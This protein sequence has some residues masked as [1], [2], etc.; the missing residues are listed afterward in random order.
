MRIEN[1]SELPK[2]NI[3]AVC[4]QTGI[5]PVTLR[6][7]ERRYGLLAP[8]RSSSNYRRYSERDVAVLRWLKAR[9]DGGAV[10]STAAA[11]LADLR[12]RN[13]WPEAPAALAPQLAVSTGEAPHKYAERLFQALAARDESAAAAVFAEVNT[14]F[15]IATA[16]AEVFTPC[17]VHVGEAWAR[18]DLLIATEHFASGFLRGRLIGVFQAM[19]IARSGPR[20][21]VGCAPTELHDIGGLM[22]AVLL[23]RRGQRVEYLG[24]DLH[25]DDLVHYAREV[26]PA[27][28]CLS[29]GM[30]EGAVALR[31]F[32]TQL[33]RLRP[34][35]L[36]GFGGRAFNADPSLRKTIPGTF[37]GE[38]VLAG[39]ETIQ[40]LLAR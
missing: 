14:L 35:P 22:L 7:W 25:L 34:R 6:A 28:I 15:D 38:T 8:T 18:G 32:Q 40:R 31:R 10:I 11:E 16:C 33:A 9:V 5:R 30:P 19:P 1:L 36:F 17:L 3:K 2:Y 20:V 21:V 13:E 37:L 29:A 39:V 26:R 12:R 4:E 23:R 24:A 27:L